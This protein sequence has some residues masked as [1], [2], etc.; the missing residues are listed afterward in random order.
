MKPCH[1][2]LGLSALF[3]AMQSQAATPG[4]D[5]DPAVLALLGKTLAVERFAPGPGLPGGDPAGVIVAAS[6]KRQPDEPTHTLAAVAWDARQADSKALV[7]AVVDDAAR[8]V[9]ALLRDEIDDAAPL[10]VNN[11]S[12]RLDT[13]PYTLA[14]G[15]RAFGLDVFH[16][17]GS[18]GEG[19]SGP[20]R[21]LYV[22]EGRTLRPVLA[23]LTLSEWQYLQGNQP[24]CTAPG[25]TAPAILEDVDV[26][27]GLGAPG[28]GGWRDLVLTA[29]SRRSDHQPGRRPLR[30]TLPYDGRAYPLAAFDKAWQRWRR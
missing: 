17:D 23:G 10:Q 22:R 14:P 5:C 16:S 26:T 9:L 8:S 3:L 18:C 1:R 24:R 2:L 7:V 19:G 28:Q 6:C 4:K 21:T 12:L 20:V 27:I 25:E 15:V 29:T 11:G 13:A 30:V